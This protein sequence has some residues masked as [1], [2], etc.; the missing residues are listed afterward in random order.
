HQ[1]VALKEFGPSAHC[2]DFHSEWTCA[3][4]SGASN[5]AVTDYTEGSS[6]ESRAHERFPD[7]FFLLLND[8]SQI[9][10]KTQHHGHHPIRKRPAETPTAIG[11]W[12]WMVQECSSE[13]SLH[14]SPQ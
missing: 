14:A 13:N 6:L 9:E 11:Q 2:G 3:R 5:A 12:R 10:C 7:S 4:R 8:S 1:R